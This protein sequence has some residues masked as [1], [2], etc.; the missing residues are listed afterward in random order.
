MARFTAGKD[1]ILPQFAPYRAKK[2]AIHPWN[3]QWFSF[4]QHPL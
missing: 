4:G 3:K 1:F 2:L